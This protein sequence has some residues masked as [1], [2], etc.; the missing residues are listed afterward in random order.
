ME[1]ETGARAAD[2]KTGMVPKTAVVKHRALQHLK[3]IYSKGLESGWE[4]K[5]TLN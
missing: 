4:K 2:R 1:T 3:K 5:I